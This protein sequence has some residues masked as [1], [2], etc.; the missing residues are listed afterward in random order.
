MKLGCLRGAICTCT[1]GVGMFAF[2][3]SLPAAFDSGGTAAVVSCL[4]GL[5][6]VCGIGLGCICDQLHEAARHSD[7]QIPRLKK[8]S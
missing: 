4:L 2:V 7:L 8:K 3:L 5:I 1:G 6:V